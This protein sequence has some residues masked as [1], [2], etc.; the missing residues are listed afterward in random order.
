MRGCYS[1]IAAT[2]A[3]IALVIIRA[4]APRGAVHVAA[5]ITCGALIGGAAA[6]TCGALIGGAAHIGGGARP[7]RSKI[8]AAPARASPPALSPP[9][10]VKDY[11][12]P[13]EGGSKVLRVIRDDLLA[14]GTKQRAVVPYIQ[15]ILA[16]NPG[17]DTVLYTAPYNGFGPLAAATGAHQLGLKCHLILSLKLFGA[18]HASSVH[19][20]NCAKPVIAARALGA[21]IEFVADWSAL[22]AAGHAAAAAGSTVWL[23]LGLNSLP[24]ELKLADAIAA[25]SRNI[26]PRRI[27]LVAG[28]GLVAKALARAF[29]AATIICVPVIVNDKPTSKLR[30]SIAQLPNMIL[31]DKHAP[32][33][34]T[35]YP[36]VFNYDSFAWD[37]AATWGCDGDF[38]WNIAG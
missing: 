36:T 20:A 17:I 19:E 28:T 34:T 13:D 37:S 4:T 7:R 21:N 33:Q 16:D 30:T 23:P 27:W 10:V 3:V 35:P 32:P 9:I 12:V 29:P 38:V 25:S 8:L 11:V 26:E 1:V 31:S 6:I 14:A 24:F 18:Q 2:V 15:S 22:N 5:A